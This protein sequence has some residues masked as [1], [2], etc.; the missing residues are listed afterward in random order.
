MSLPS[1]RMS[2]PQATFWDHLDALRGVIVRS[3]VAVML[4]GVV[5]F[6]LKEPLFRLVLAPHSSHFVTFRALGVEPFS[7][8]LMNTGLTEQLMIHIRVAL[9]FGLLVASPYVICQLFRFVSPGLYAGERRLSVRV[10]AWSYVLFMAGTAL[11]YL[12]IFPLAVRFLG[13]YQ[14]SAE[15]ANMLT[16]QSYI[17]TLL[18]MSLMMGLVFQVPVVCAVLGR[19]GLLSRGMMTAY[20]RHALVVILIVAAVVTPTTD[21]VTLLLVSLPVWLLYEVSVWLV[22]AKSKTFEN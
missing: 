18:T 2:E 10:V 5:A 3:L 22:P 6:V 11:N 14:V 9:Y 19:V 8:S 15:V 13:T 7:L 4:A 20:R 21:V 16:L 1:P 12:L 17:D